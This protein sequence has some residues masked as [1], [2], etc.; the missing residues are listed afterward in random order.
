MSVQGPPV[1]E[2]G[3]RR[4]SFI[5]VAF[6]PLAIALNLA[7]G[8]IVHALKLPL[9]LDAVGTIATTLLFGWRAGIV[10]GVGS[11]LLAGVTLNPVL[12]WFSATQAAIA[13]YTYLINRVGGFRSYFRTLLSGLGLGVVAGAISA[14]VIAYLFGGITGS[15]SSLVVG[16]LLS[17]GHRLLT[18]VFLSGLASE[19]IDKAIQSLLAVWLVRGLPPGLVNSIRKRK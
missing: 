5:V 7:L 18:S 2:S 12:P 19:P 10:T 16:W 1:R 17:T 11:F 3:D 15:G 9:Y 14:P 6:V 13:V 8:S 4:K